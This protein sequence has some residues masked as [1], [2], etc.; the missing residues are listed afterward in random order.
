MIFPWFQAGHQSEA[1][2]R[3]FIGAAWGY[4][5][6]RWDRWDGCMVILGD[7]PW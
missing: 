1:A 7:F 2:E 4:Q 3:N 5:A 6:G